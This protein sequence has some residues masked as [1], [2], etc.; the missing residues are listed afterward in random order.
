MI[1][2]NEFDLSDGI[3]N[4]VRNDPYDAGDCDI[5]CTSLIAP[6]RLVALRKRYGGVLVEDASD[7]IWALLGQAI[8]TILERA[9][10]NDNESIVER[11][12]FA[13]VAGWTISGQLDRYDI[14]RQ[15][16]EDYKVTSTW[17]VIGDPKPEWI[18]QLNVLAWLARENGLSVKSLRICAILRDWQKKKAEFDHGN[19]PKHNVQVVDIPMWEDELVKEYITSRVISHQ[20]AENMTDYELPEC[21]SEEK[22]EKDTVFAVMKTGRKSAIKLCS[23]YEE[24][25][26]VMK[27]KGGTHIDVREGECTRCKYY[28]PASSYCQFSGNEN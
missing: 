16:L 9:G 14:K 18:A 20:E 2:T 6:V 13:N 4:A 15:M 17:S 23:S 8:H 25:E 28:C 27:A 11:R 1:I 26:E 7:R 21:T 5:S 3:V 24:A 22:W 19:Y 10:E 12:L